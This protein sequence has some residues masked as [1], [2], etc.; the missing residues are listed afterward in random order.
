MK[1]AS[2]LNMS[3]KDSFVVNNITINTDASFYAKQKVGGWAFYIRYGNVVLRQSGPFKVP[4]KSS[5]DAEI[6]C[7]ANAVYYLLKQDLPLVRK[8]III[9]GD[10]TYAF[11]RIGKKS[12]HPV[13]REI[14]KMLKELRRRT[15]S[16]LTKVPKCDFRYVQAHNGTPDARS[17]VNDWCDRGAKRWS[18]IQLNQLQ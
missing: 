9:N 8:Y 1:L 2:A 5:L 11:Q 16:D 17:W 13:G 3:N 10:C 15:A 14:A 18:K 4:P 6:Q 12:N 7:I